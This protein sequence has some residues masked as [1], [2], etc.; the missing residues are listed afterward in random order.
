MNITVY[1]FGEFNNGYT[2]YPDDYT[3][4]KFKNFYYNA[5]STTQIVIHREGDLMYYGY[6]R[7]L[8][9]DRYIGFCVVINGLMLTKLD[10]LFS[11][12]EST[13][14]KLVTN[15]Q[16]IHFNKEGSIVTNVDKLYMNLEE[17]DL[18][19]ESFRAGFHHFMGSVKALPAINYS[20]S[21][22][23]I[24]NVS[25][26]ENIDEIIRSSH[27]YSYTFI[28]KSK[29][30][31]TNQLNS[32]KEILNKLNIEKVELSNKNDELEKIL[33]KTIREKKQ[34]HI[35]AILFFVVLICLIVFI[36]LNSNLNKTKSDLKIADST[37]SEQSS[38][39]SFN[40]GQITSLQSD[41]LS[42]KNEYQNTKNN[43]DSLQAIVSY[44]QPF[45][46]KS[47]S[48]DYSTG[49]LTLNYYGFKDEL[50]ALEVRVY[51]NYGYSYKTSTT[52]NVYIGENTTQVFL[53]LGL[54]SIEWYTFVILKNNIII[55][56]D[57]L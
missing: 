54:S 17:I 8:E 27:T 34:N 46:I 41:N 10:G 5:K 57:R 9:Q 40:A 39:L 43:L 3:N 29:G 7:K 13:I 56:G 4:T 53:S 37:I 19:T 26:E 6:I 30:F 45:I 49:N 55:G 16:L 50:V 35:I 48:F 22:D 25:I 31:N 21:K 28:Y 44:R 36:S 20:V 15:G 52:V 24:K 1:L 38:L 14:S 33:E 47:T 51:D 32:Y 12:F 18:L 2:Q 23:S 42:L 11:L